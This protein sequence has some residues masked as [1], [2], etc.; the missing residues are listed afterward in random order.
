MNILPSNFIDRTIWGSRLRSIPKAYGTG[1]PDYDVGL[2]GHLWMHVPLTEAQLRSIWLLS[3]VD[4]KNPQ[5]AWHKIGGQTSFLLSVNGYKERVNILRSNWLAVFGFILSN[6]PGDPNLI[7]VG[8]VAR[9]TA[10]SI[11]ALFRLIAKILD[12]RSPLPRQNAS[13]KGSASP[14]HA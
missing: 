6:G 14:G 12:G 5:S 11:P 4:T 2:D 7:E 10:S 9:A 1:R 8:H 3:G 13:Q